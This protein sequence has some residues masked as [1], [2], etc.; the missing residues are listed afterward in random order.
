M[1]ILYGTLDT[2][3]VLPVQ[4]N[5][6][7]QLIAEGLKGED[8]KD[9]V[10]GKDGEPVLPTPYGEE[11]SYLYIKDGEPAWSTEDM[12]AP[13]PDT[14]PS[15]HLVNEALDSRLKPYD[16]AGNHISWETDFDTWIRTTSIFQ[17]GTNLQRT[18]LVDLECRA[19]TE[20]SVTGNF[21]NALGAIFSIGFASQCWGSHPSTWPP[22]EIQFVA[23]PDEWQYVTK[24]YQGYAGDGTVGNNYQASAY[25]YGE[26]SYLILRDEFECTFQWF[27]RMQSPSS[28]PNAFSALQRWWLEDTE[29][30]LMRKHIEQQQRSRGN[31]KRTGNAQV[32]KGLTRSHYEYG[33]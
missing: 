17:N 31:A 6:K 18:G 24:S 33:Y 14:G 15:F 27:F 12:P 32:S 30:Y 22:N 13:E 9:G 28:N 2:G 16:D 1:A 20:Y 29:T 19:N 4:V 7:G 5:S 26:H 23:K 21:K 3:E 8:G 25:A 10:D 11:G